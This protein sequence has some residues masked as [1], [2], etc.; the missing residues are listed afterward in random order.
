[1]FVICFP[2]TF[3][4]TQ[5]IYIYIYCVCVCVF[6]CSYICTLMSTYTYIFSRELGG[7]NVCEN[8]FHLTYKSVFKLVS[9]CEYIIGLY[10][11]LVLIYLCCFIYSNEKSLVL[12]IYI[13]ELLLILCPIH[14]R[15]FD[16]LFPI[17]W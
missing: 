16:A 4:S 8:A 6:V 17:S 9:V 5:G 14:L 3:S 1:M 13:Q 7:F 12:Y 11:M 2:L 15:C 10:L